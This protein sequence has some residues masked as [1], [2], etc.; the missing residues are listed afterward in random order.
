MRCAAAAGLTLAGWAVMMCAAETIYVDPQAGDNSYTGFCQIWDGSYCGPKRTIQAAVDA[1]QNGDR[2][3]LAPGT[4]SGPGN[5]D[6]SFAGLEIRIESSDPSNAAIVAET[7]IDCGAGSDRHRAF[8][9]VN[10]EGEESV[11]AGVTISNG[12]A[13]LEYYPPLGEHLPAGGAI[14]CDQSYPTIERCR[15]VQ[16]NSLMGGA[17]VTWEFGTG[18]PSGGGMNV[19][20]VQ[21]TGRIANCL[22]VSNETHVYSPVSERFYGSG[23]AIDINGDSFALHHWRIENCEFIDNR[24]QDGLGTSIGGGAVQVQDGASVEIDGCVFRENECMSGQAGGNGGA[25]LVTASADVVLRACS[26]SSNFAERS[27]GAIYC[28]AAHLSV[29]ACR[30]NGNEAPLD[31]DTYGGAIAAGEAA[32]IAVVNCEFAGNVAQKGG[33]LGLVRSDSDLFVSNCTLVGNRAQSGEAV[34]WNLGTLEMNNSVVWNGLQWSPTSEI[35]LNYC[36]VQGGWQWGAG[37]TGEDPLFVQL[38]FWD[39]NGTPQNKLD[40]IWVP[41]DHRVLLGS[42]CIDAGNNEL[43]MRDEF[44]L[45]GDGNLLEPIPLDLARFPRFRDDLETPDAGI[46]APPVVDIG[47]WEYHLPVVPGDTNCDRDVTFADINPFILRL[48]NVVS[49]QSAFPAC[50]DAHSDVNQDGVINFE[51]INPFI[52]LLTSP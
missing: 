9:F 49:Y 42:S 34:W 50:P 8:E 30:F 11:L 44:D 36:V 4:Y 28:E 41:G 40:D 52:L 7:I 51:D 38:G 14:F 19:P 35:E 3:E 15:F 23:G 32:N 13:P 33:A 20:D 48:S 22:F 47:A 43:A 17:I 21:H 37:N 29:V 46:G 24:C 45:D 31:F 12:L 18:G 2:I 1:A 16:N 39:L 5:R 10:G 6:I 26:F 27:G 25:L